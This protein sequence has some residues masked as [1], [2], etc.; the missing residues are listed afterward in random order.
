MKR[1]SLVILAFILALILSACESEKPQRENLEYDNP[2]ARLVGAC[3][4]KDENSFMSCFTVGA[5]KDFEGLELQAVEGISGKIFE[6]CGEFKAIDYEVTGKREITEDELKALCDEYNSQ[7][8][9]RL[10]AKKGYEL[11]VCFSFKGD[12]NGY[13]CEKTVTTVKTEGGWFI[14]GDVITELDFISSPQA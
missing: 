14:Y 2:V 1:A 8:G 5:R 11:E 3:N 9:L 13:R 6:L 7:Y 4:K 10:D 12:A